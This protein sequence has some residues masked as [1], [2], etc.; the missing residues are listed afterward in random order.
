MTLVTLN[1]IVIRSSDIERSVQFYEALGFKFTWHQH[2]EGLEH[3][4]AEIA[5]GD[6]PALVFEIYPATNL[7]DRK[8]AVRLGFSVED[9]DAA[10]AAL[11]A[12][13]GNVISRARESEWGR[14]AVLSDP[15]G[16]RVELTQRYIA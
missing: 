14:R 6:A 11:V 1:L 9:V 10:L 12:A 4:A 3:Y 15:D 13:G 7:G 8:D 2:G 16:H 5:C